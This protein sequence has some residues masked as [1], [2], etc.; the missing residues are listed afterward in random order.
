MVLFGIKRRVKHFMCLGVGN[1]HL[2]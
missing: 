1:V 2:F